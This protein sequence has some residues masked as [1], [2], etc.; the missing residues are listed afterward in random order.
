MIPH[1]KALVERLKNEPFA[2]VGVNTDTS[3]DDYR[4]KAKD[5]G[6][7]WRSAWDGSTSGP[8]CRQW[9]VQSFPTVY[10]IDAKG[11]LRF[12]GLRGEPLSQA[13]DALLKEMK[14]GA[15]GPREKAGEKPAGATP[16]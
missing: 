4:A 15:P 3:K 9:R 1:E 16:H 14:S 5:M 11:V 10:V 7:T 13:V 12:T 8:V 2:L 6:V